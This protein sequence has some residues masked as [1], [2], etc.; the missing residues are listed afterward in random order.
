[1]LWGI[2]S[3]D[4][5]SRYLHQTNERAAVFKPRVPGSSPSYLILMGVKGFRLV[6]REQSEGCLA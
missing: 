1:M 4:Y 2:Q 5:M 3:I 6:V